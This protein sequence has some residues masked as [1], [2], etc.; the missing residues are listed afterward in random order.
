M[1]ECSYEYYIIINMRD[2]LRF[3]KSLSDPTR[4]RILHLLMHNDLCVCELTSILK[5]EQSRISHQ[6]RIL[7]NAELIEDRREGK[8]IIYRIKWLLGCALLLILAWMIL[9]WFKKAEL[10]EWV[11]STWIFAKHIFALLFAGVLAA[12]FLLGRPGHEG[13]IP[14]QWVASLVGG[15]NLGS[16]LFASVAG[17]LMYFATLTEVPILQG[18]LGAGMGQGPALALLL[19]GPALSL[20]SMLVLR[21]IMG[22]KKTLAYITLVVVMATLTG[23]LYG[24]LF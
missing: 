16:N 15:N 14:S 7:R 3:F 23:M 2:V 11:F 1:I 20:P 12:G 13:I 6:L 21:S 4:L 17:A 8:W 9:E 24:Y 10:K 5:M 19:A 18:L 22:T